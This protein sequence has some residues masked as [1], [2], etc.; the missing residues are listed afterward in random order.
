VTCAPPGFELDVE[1]RTAAVD[2]AGLETNSYT[3]EDNTAAGYYDC[4]KSYDCGDLNSPVQCSCHLDGEPSPAAPS[5]TQLP[6]TGIKLTIPPGVSNQFGYDVAA[7][8]REP[9]RPAF[10]IGTH[11]YAY[12]QFFLPAGQ[13]V[14]ARVGI[15]CTPTINPDLDVR[16]CHTE[17]WTTAGVWHE[18]L[19]PLDPTVGDFQTVE[20]ATQNCNAWVQCV[21][22]GVWP[23]GAGDALGGSCIISR[24]EVAGYRDICQLDQNDIELVVDDCSGCLLSHDLTSDGSGSWKT[25]IP[26]VLNGATMTWHF[27]G[28]DMIQWCKVKRQF[29]V[30]MPGDQWLIDDTWAQ[31]TPTYSTGAVIRRTAH[32]QVVKQGMVVSSTNVGC[33]MTQQN[34][35]LDQTPALGHHGQILLDTGSIL[36]L[37]EASVPNVPCSE[38]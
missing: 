4:Y 12:A 16:Q 35:N 10:K 27:S 28:Q 29:N 38:P 22:S 8:P 3:C 32:W 36:S 21:N 7:W 1:K 18:A 26:G 33:S 13:D 31:V 6:G 11:V 15:D 24:L 34:V 2:K 30:H 25:D 23:P 20:E 9:H 37:G 5:C 19:I 14:T 17:A